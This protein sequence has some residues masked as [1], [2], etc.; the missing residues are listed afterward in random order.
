VNN[1][2]PGASS[3]SGSSEAGDGPQKVTLVY[4]IGGCTYAEVA[5]LRFL[6][7]QDNGKKLEIRIRNLAVNNLH[8]II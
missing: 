7:I 8:C 4:F 3:L 1:S 5:A 6:S 2:S